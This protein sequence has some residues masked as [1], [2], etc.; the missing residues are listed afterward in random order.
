MVLGRRDG[1]GSASF[2]HAVIVAAF[3]RMA[4]SRSS[5]LL[6]KCGQRRAHDR[7]D[8][9][10]REWNSAQPAQAEDNATVTL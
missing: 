5:P 6:D 1:L 10:P 3:H 7:G 4:Q 2:T 8:G 9:I